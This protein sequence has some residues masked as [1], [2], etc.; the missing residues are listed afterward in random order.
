MVKVE[1]AIS[2]E[3][4]IKIGKASKEISRGALIIPS[5]GAVQI[6]NG[7]TVNNPPCHCPS[8]IKILKSVF[9]AGMPPNPATK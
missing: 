8:V 7:G 9:P 1:V 6:T 4:E 2:L 3:K 5:I